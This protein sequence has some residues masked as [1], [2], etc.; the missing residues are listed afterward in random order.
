[1]TGL[2]GDILEVQTWSTERI[3]RGR[4]GIE[5]KESL[6]DSENTEDQSIMTYKK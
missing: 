4:K 2:Q 1:M 3:L 6:K 5:R